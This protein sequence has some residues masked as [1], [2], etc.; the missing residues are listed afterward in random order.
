MTRLI[1]ITTS[2]TDPQ[3]SG[4]DPV[5][6]GVRRQDGAA[7]LEPLTQRRLQVSGN[8]DHDR[9]RLERDQMIDELE[10]LFWSQ[11][12]LHDDHLVAVP[13]AVAGLCRAES[14]DR[15]AE[16]RRGRPQALREQEFVLDEEQIPSHGCRI[17]PDRDRQS[18]SHR[19]NGLGAC[20]N[21]ARE[22]WVEGY[23]SLRRNL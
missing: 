14:L 23:G 13:G 21:R 7:R 4:Q 11:G 3:G 16:P 5:H 18:F 19:Q 17:A 12:G 2:I 15:D 22:S 9:G 20:Y 6:A 8:R 10:L 1:P